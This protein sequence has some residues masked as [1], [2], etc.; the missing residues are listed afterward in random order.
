M[1][2]AGKSCAVLAPHRDEHEDED[3]AEEQRPSHDD[4]SHFSPQSL[5]V[6]RSIFRRVPAREGP[7]QLPNRP[8][9]SKRGRQS[10]PGQQRP[11]AGRRARSFA[12]WAQALRLRRRNG[13]PRHATGVNPCPQDALGATDLAQG[14][15]RCAL[16]LWREGAGLVR[17]SRLTAAGSAP[18]PAGNWVDLRVEATCDACVREVNDWWRD[19]RR[20]TLVRNGSTWCIEG[21]GSDRARIAYA[22]LDGDSVVYRVAE[23]TDVV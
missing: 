8:G 18:S 15:C 7:G 19:R 12:S 4:P 23:S 6:D 9:E 16:A 10:R 2:G 22:S 5:A 20:M 1:L 21:P 17:H 14:E 13:A 3:D 11:D